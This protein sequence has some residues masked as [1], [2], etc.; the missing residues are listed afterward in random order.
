MAPQTPKTTSPKSKSPKSTSPKFQWTKRHRQALMVLYRQQDLDDA[1]IATAFNQ[2]FQTNLSKSAVTSQYGKSYRLKTKAWQQVEACEEADLDWVVQDLKALRIRTKSNQPVHTTHL[3]GAARPASAIRPVHTIKAVGVTKSVPRPIRVPEPVKIP[4][5]VGI[6]EATRTVQPAKATRP[7]KETRPAKTTQPAANPA[8]QAPSRQLLASNV[9]VVID[10]PRRV[11]KTAVKPPR[12]VEKTA[13][14]SRNIFKKFPEDMAVSVNRTRTVSGMQIPI[15]RPT[16]KDLVVNDP[17][18]PQEAHSA[19]PEL[20]FRFHD[21]NSQGIKTP[22]GFVASYYS[23]LTTAPPAPPPCSDDRLFATVLNH[24]NKVRFS[25]E[26][27]STTSNLFFAMRLAAKSNANPRICVVRGSVLPYQKV[28]HAYPY[29]L[30]YKDARM[31]FN[32]TY[33]NPSSHEYLIWATIPRTAILC[34]IAFKDIERHL[35]GNPEMD[36]ALRIEALRSRDGNPNLQKKFAREKVDLTLGLTEGLARFLPAFGVD[37]N[38]PGPVIARL[39]S[40]LVRGFKIDLHK[41]SPTRWDMLA[42]AFAFA[43]T[44]R[45]RDIDE[46]QLLCAK[47]AFLAG[48][49]IGIG[50]LNWHLSPSKRVKMLRKE[51][52]LGLGANSMLVDQV[53]IPNSQPQQQQKSIDL[54]AEDDEEAE[55]DVELGSDVE[56][57]N[58]L[59]GKRPKVGSKFQQPGPEDEEAETEVEDENM[60]INK[61]RK[62]QMARPNRWRRASYPTDQNLMVYDRSDDDD[63][64]MEDEIEEGEDDDSEWDVVKTSKRGRQSL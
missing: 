46:R 20:L 60:P 26:L 57:E 19:V 48:V 61:N 8:S 34:D 18:T 50:E 63:F 38:A 58:V 52:Q 1:N 27:I 2:L 44:E 4:K 41:T 45:D 11:E 51:A 28:Y 39:I 64:V 56:Y 43:L 24:L 16:D 36:A 22:D 5:P 10:T 25:S 14:R 33:M 32:G 37:A 12:R 47:E 30:R 7:T 29:H 40:E 53:E 21:D 31:F 59:A 35:A 62:V 49:R 42:S 55:T 6:P 3:A 23:F 13:P 15:I 54:T 9:L 17:M